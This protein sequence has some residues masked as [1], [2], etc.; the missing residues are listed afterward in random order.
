MVQL[1]FALLV[2]AVLLQLASC[3]KD[4]HGIDDWNVEHIQDFLQLH[5][6]CKISLDSL[7]SHDLVDG[8]AFVALSNDENKTE[9]ILKDIINESSLLDNKKA[10][11]TRTHAAIKKELNKIPVDFYEWRVMN[12]RLMNFWILPLSLSPRSLLIWARFFDTDPNIELINDEIDEIPIHVFWAYWLVSPSALISKIVHKFNTH[13]FLDEMLEGDSQIRALYE[14][15]QL[16][17]CCFN[18]YALHLIV[19]VISIFKNSIK[20]EEDQLSNTRVN[21]E[22]KKTDSSIFLSLFLKQA[23]REIRFFLV[24]QVFYYGLYHVCPSQYWDSIFVIYVYIL[25]PWELVKIGL[26]LSSLFQ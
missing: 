6:K 9:A 22:V 23:G 11:I 15:L 12:M 18:L 7:I 17:L 25:K 16:I 8:H 24:A 5:S 20:N 10:R 4:H 13:T 19:Q 14:V 26:E 3:S 1:I 21:A 2:I